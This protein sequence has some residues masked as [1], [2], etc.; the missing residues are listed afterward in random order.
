MGGVNSNSMVNV[1]QTVIGV[2]SINSTTSFKIKMADPVFDERSL[3][4]EDSLYKYCEVITLGK[5]ND[6]KR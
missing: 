5:Q 3:S 4:M 1:N 6:I 2:L